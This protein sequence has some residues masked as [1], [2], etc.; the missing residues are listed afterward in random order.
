MPVVEQHISLHEKDPISTTTTFDGGG[1][2]V[3]QTDSD[4]GYVT[5][6]IVLTRDGITKR[7]TDTAH[8]VADA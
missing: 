3:T 1:V 2:C 8:T 5:H 7:V 6:R 4:Y